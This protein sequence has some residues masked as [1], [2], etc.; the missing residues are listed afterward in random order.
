[1]PTYEVELNGQKFEI[2]APD[3]SAVNLAVKQLQSQSAAPENPPVEGGYS[4]GPGWTK[5]A[6]AFGSGIADMALT[7]LRR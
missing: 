6:T 2:D 1:M 5:P 3:D 4:G 7:R